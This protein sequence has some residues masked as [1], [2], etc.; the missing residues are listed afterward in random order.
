MLSVS[1]AQQ[2]ILSH[3]EPVEAQTLPLEQSAGRVL[4]QDIFAAIDLPLFDNSGVDGFALHASDLERVRSTGSITLSVIADIPAGSSTEITLRSGQAARI[5]TGA[6]VPE[7]AEAVVMVEDTDFND[8]AP[9]TP[10]PKNVTVYKPTKSNTNIRQRGEDM[11]TGTKVLSRGQRLRPQDLGLLAMLGVATVPVHRRPRL[12]LLSSG[13]ELIPLEATLTPGKVRDSNTYTLSAQAAQSGVEVVR[14]GVAADERLAV[15]SMLERA[16]AE[17]I[18]VIVSSAGVSVGA[19]D[20]IKD[21]VEE[22]GSLDFWKVN[23]RPGKPLAFGHYGRAIGDH[24]QDI[25]FFGLP[26]NPV[27]AFIGFEV[28][29][30]P[31]LERLGGAIP[32]P[33]PRQ[34]ARLAGPVNTDGRET[35]LRAVVTEENGTLVARLTGHQGSGN[36]LSLVQANAL[37]IVPSG[38]KSLPANAEAEV[39]ML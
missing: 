3:F 27:S 18:D 13:D 6:P 2:R 5:M 33:R 25:P 21:V 22:Q 29:V 36:L 20:F 28:F 12:A 38:V 14:L 7:G 8:R 19:F 35:Y 1:E 9:G 31:A 37:L 24:Y 26:G 17:G 30:R 11:R 16:V 32:Q 23:M 34:H 39:W 4:A 15:Q 10:V